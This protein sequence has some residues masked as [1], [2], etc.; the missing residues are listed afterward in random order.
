MLGLTIAGV[1]V[2]FTVALLVK[3]F[4]PPAVLFSAGL[5]LFAATAAFDFGTVLD[6]AR[7][8]N[9]VG[10]DIFK[11]F[12]TG[13]SERI[14][15]LGLTLM[16]IGGFSRYMEYVGASSALFAV[17]EK[18][19]KRIRSP[20]M[21]LGAA[22]LVSQVIVIFMPSHAGIALLLMV[23]VYPILIRSGVSK[24]SALGVIGCGQFMDVGPGPGSAILTAQ[25]ADVDVAEYF[26]YWQLPLF[27]G[28]TLILAVVHVV[29]QRWWDKREGWVYDPEAAKAALGGGK[30]EEK[31]AP[32]IYAVLPVIPLILIICFSKVVG[33]AIKMDVAT[34]MVIATWI[35]GLFELVR[36]RSLKKVLESFRVYFEGMG[37]I[38]VG[39]VSL[40]ICGEFFAAG[41]IKSGALATII[42]AAE[43]AGAGLGVM[44]LFGGLI[45][46]SMAFIMGSG[47]A[48]FFSF[49]PL[50]PAIASS[51]GAPV[52]HLLFPL[53]TLV[54]F[55]RVASPITAAIVAISVMAEV[56]PFQV[57]KRTAIPMAVAAVLSY[58]YFYL[59]LL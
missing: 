45:M 18:P 20:Y 34:A 6:A 50:C 15:G 30:T 54:S 27:V 14:A 11:V 8:T 24:L 25:L 36:T 31:R 19:L 59:M 23:T 42:A 3:G 26:V 41:L 43:S 28:L 7:T 47:N 39:V 10:F 52:L 49:A 48:A 2:L 37:K 56:S 51:V 5:V 35:S 9:F 46:I 55:G 53:Q 40:I 32:K 57:A 22:F 58:G 17:F 38:L 12:T 21:L 33:S 44:V 16:A 29:V 4:Y 13:F 1:V